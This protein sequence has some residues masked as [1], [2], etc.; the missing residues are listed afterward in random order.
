MLNKFH[1]VIGHH[2]ICW[3]YSFSTPSQQKVIKRITRTNFP[4]ALAELV[5]SP[6]KAKSAISKLVMKMK[7]EMRSIS[8]ISHD[9]LLSDPVQAVKQFN[10]GSVLLELQQ[11]MPTLM[12]FLCAVVGQAFSKVPLTC[13]IASMILKSRHQRMSLVQRVISTGMVLPSR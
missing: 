8:S 6:T 10:W 12:H 13:L 4:A 7:S 9:S 3:W 5:S 2:S 1:C 11:K